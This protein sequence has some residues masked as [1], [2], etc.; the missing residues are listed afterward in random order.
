MPGVSVE[1]GRNILPPGMVGDLG[2]GIE[3]VIISMSVDGFWIVNGVSRTPVLMP[4]S[5]LVL[6]LGVVL[7][8]GICPSLGE[9]VSLRDGV[10]ARNGNTPALRDGFTLNF[11]VE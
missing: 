9:N 8:L 7:V 10:D 4:V 6:I 5:I 11:G 1:P 2:L 3:L